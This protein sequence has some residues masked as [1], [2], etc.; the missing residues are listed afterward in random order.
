[1]EDELVSVGQIVGAHGILGEFRVYPLTDFP[2]RFLDTEC[3]YLGNRSRRVEV[4]S[5]RQHGNVWLFKIK[6]V[7]TREAAEKLRN[8]YLKI[9]PDDVVPLPADNYYTYQLIGLTVETDDGQKLGEVSDV[10]TGTGNDL[11]VVKRP[12][13]RDALIP[14]VKAFVN[15]VDINARLIVVSLIPGLLE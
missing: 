8:G 11:L 7:D 4:L 6:G 14:F 10:I 2:E 13:Q 1:V 3:L 15:R 5:V 9:E 12:G